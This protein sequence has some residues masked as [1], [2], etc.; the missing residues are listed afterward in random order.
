MLQNAEANCP[1]IYEVSHF[2]NNFDNLDSNYYLDQTE[3]RIA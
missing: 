3:T 2:R 1:H